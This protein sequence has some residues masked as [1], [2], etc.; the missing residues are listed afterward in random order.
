MGCVVKL[1]TS[2]LLV[3]QSALRKLGLHHYHVFDYAS[4]CKDN[5]K[6]AAKFCSF[7]GLL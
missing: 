5:K 7:H 3:Q 2:L 6:R 1:F 4:V